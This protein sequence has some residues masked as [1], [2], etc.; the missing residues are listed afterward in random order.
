MTLPTRFCRLAWLVDDYDALVV[1]L[2]KMMDLKMRTASVVPDMIKVGIEEHGLEPIEPILPIDQ[3]PFMKGVPGP[4]FE[5]ALAVDNCD[6]SYRRMEK[7][8]LLPSFTSPLPGP[9]THEH[10]YAQGF[11]NVPTMV[12]TDGDNE[13]MMAP[14]LDLEKAAPPK[15]AVCT[16]LVEDVDRF[17]AKYTKYFD[18]E[19][20]ETD[21]AGLGTRALVGKHRIKLVEGAD[22]EIRKHVMDPMISAEFIYPNHEEMRDR[23]VA[24]GYPVLRERTFK[25]GR[26]QWYFG[27]VLDGLPISIFHPDDEAEALGQ[28]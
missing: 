21:P 23:L 25:S 11:E 22:A 10:F 8:G 12:C 28:A 20:V 27:A 6:E 2:D 15:V 19:W 9:D 18:M 4:F 3:L 5:V 17:A 24:A 1:K 13:A 14:F 16:V 7:D 26:K